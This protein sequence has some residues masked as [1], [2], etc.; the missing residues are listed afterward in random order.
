MSLNGL[1][2]FWFRDCIQPESRYE[3]L[4]SI[5]GGG[6][7]CGGKSKQG[8]VVD[9]KGD[10]SMK[11]RRVTFAEAGSLKT[12]MVAVVVEVKVGLT[13]CHF[14]CSPIVIFVRRF[15]R[16]IYA[17]NQPTFKVSFDYFIFFD[18]FRQ[19]Y[20]CWRFFF[21]MKSRTLSSQG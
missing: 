11:R 19:S 14:L 15:G 1:W 13:R 5:S 20:L 3:G 21:H 16:A 7:G 17:G 6:R 12:A 9:S 18:C 2:L 8:V 4:R 10:G